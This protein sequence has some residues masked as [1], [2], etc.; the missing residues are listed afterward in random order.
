MP[1]NI[2]GPDPEDRVPPLVWLVC[3]LVIVG[4]LAASL[5]E[6]LS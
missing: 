5:L 3:V 4:Y 6:P 2:L 1:N